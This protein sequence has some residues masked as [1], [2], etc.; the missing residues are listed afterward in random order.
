MLAIATSVMAT[1]GTI[2]KEEEESAIFE[3]EKGTDVDNIFAA[4]QGTVM[5]LSYNRS[6]K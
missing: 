2:G 3:M 1:P 5:E 6:P 4:L